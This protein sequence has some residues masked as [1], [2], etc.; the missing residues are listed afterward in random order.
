ML[1]EILKVKSVEI[2]KNEKIFKITFRVPYHYF[3]Q[4]IADVLT[5]NLP[6]FPNR[7]NMSDLIKGFFINISN[8]K[9]H[10]CKRQYLN[11]STLLIIS[12]DI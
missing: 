12:F 1:F 10:K 9:T 7:N 6:V 8:G 11:N 3:S 2:R 5:F 4:T